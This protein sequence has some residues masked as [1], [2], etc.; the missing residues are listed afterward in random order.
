YIGAPKEIAAACSKVQGQFTSGANS[1]AQQASIAALKKDPSFL[2]EML[3]AF[4][5]RRKLVLDAL[6]SMKG[7]EV[8]E[9]EGAFYFFPNITSFFGKSYEGKSINNAKD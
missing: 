8:N 9:P 5:K 4:K 2:N 6:K 3:N 1:I 7:V